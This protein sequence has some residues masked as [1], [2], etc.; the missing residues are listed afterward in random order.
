MIKNLSKNKM[1]YLASPYSYLGN[2]RLIGWMVRWWR[3]R[4]V[5]DAAVYLIKNGYTC[6]EPIATC[7]YKSSRY[8]LPTGYQYW[9][10]RDRWFI[11][12]CEGI[13]VLTLNGWIDSEGVQDE[14][15]YARSRGLDVIYL[16][17]KTYVT[18]KE[19]KSTR[20]FKTKSTKSQ[21]FLNDKK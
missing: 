17:P 3:F 18:T 11:R 14:I 20:K 10:R 6:I 1:Y 21:G 8:D 2:N 15:Q 9:Q 7:H 4:K 12:K 5:S 19:I 16:D 13:I